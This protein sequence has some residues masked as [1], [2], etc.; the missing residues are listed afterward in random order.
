MKLSL[1]QIA[2]WVSGTLHIPRKDSHAQAAT[3]YSIDSRTLRPGDL[4]FAVR[5]ERLDGHDYV[6]PALAAGASGAVVDGSRLG[7]Y[8]AAAQPQLLG[9]PNVLEALQKLAAAV[10]RNWG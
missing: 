8:P 2:Y 5:G 6:L 7:G 3:G 1:E 9:V 10:R 4:F